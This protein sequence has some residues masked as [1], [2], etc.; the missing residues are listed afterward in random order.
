MA[1]TFCVLLL[2]LLANATITAQTNYEEKN[3]KELAAHPQQDAYRL[4]RLTEL[5]FYFNGLTAEKEKYVLEALTIAQKTSNA[6]EQGK[7]MGL[8]AR[9]AFAKGNQAQSDSLYKK[10]DSIAAAS[11]DKELQAM[12]LVGKAIRYQNTGKNNEAIAS[13]ANAVK[14]AYEAGSKRLISYAQFQM[15]QTYLNGIGDY[16]KAVEYFLK[17]EESAGQANDLIMLIRSWT[18][19]EGAY[20]SISDYD[21]ALFYLEKA[22]AANKQYGSKQIDAIILNDLGE[23]YRLTG[24]YD[25]AIENYSNSLTVYLNNF[26][27]SINV[28]ISEGNLA[29]VYVRVNNLPLAFQY[30]FSAY[31]LEKEIENQNNLSWIDGVLSR[32]Y[33][34]KQMPDSA[35]YYANEGFK[36]ASE[37]DALESMRDNLLALA[38]AYAYKKNFEQAYKYHLQYITYRD[39]LLNGEIK[40]K[41]AIQKFS[42]DLEKKQQEITSLDNQKNDQ[43]KI[44]YGTIALLGLILLMLFLTY[45]NN[46]HKQKTNSILQ[47]TLSNLKST[48]SQLIQSEKM[49]S[50][51]ELTAGIAHEIQNPLNFVNNFS[52]VSNELMDEM[53]VEFRKGNTYDAF[54]IADEIKQNLEKI[55]Y[56]GKRADAIVKGMLQHSRKSEGKKE[57]TNINTLC[58]EY[59]RLS[60]HGLRAKDKSFNAEMKTNFD[61]SAGKINI[62]PQDIGRVLLNLINNAF[63]AVNEKKKTAGENY[64][65]EISVETKKTND[66]VTINVTDNGSGIPAT[67]T[68][69]IFQPFFTTK[70][71]GSGTGLGL[72]L[73]YDIIKAHNGQI[74]VQTTEGKGT[75]FSIVLPA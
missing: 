10:A 24:K 41:I 42:S 52:D 62:I 56:H 26:H 72:S 75:T 30:A 39:S 64:K 34:K 25:L 40:N 1:R 2:L 55:N 12:L 35:I 3:S 53:K 16:Q 4:N 49:A 18:G 70:P 61:E 28:G 58:D 43:L 36:F 33:L 71:T 45:R 9:V 21:Q 8:L 66:T 50:L 54:Q 46:R 19:L 22:K 31:K 5:A 27:N 59:L 51:G 73:S 20:T 6:I 57:P 15:G 67:L 37:S 44:L 38:D 23:V 17:S 32:A 7:A 14:L 63:Y 60:Y 11:G 13:L 47:T 29:D 74:S 65:P 69:K 68:E 48:Q